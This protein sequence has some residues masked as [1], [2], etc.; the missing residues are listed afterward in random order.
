[1]RGIIEHWSARAHAPH[2]RRRQR[3]ATHPHFSPLPNAHLGG[4]KALA[5]ALERTGE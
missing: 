1:M 3:D 4:V 2:D 5:E